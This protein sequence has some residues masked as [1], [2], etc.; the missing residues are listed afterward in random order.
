MDKKRTGHSAKEEGTVRCKYW[1]KVDHAKTSKDD[2]R[3]YAKDEWSRKEVR[4]QSR[5]CGVD[6]SV[7]LGSLSSIFGD[8]D[9]GGFRQFGRRFK[10]K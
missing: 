5:I 9:G 3:L 8:A 2:D 6:E 10:R 7:K 4:A 1:T